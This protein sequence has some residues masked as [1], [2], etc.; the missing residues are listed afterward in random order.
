MSTILVIS[1]SHGANI[2]MQRVLSEWARRVDLI[3]FCGDGCSDITTNI[4]T[5]DIKTPCIKVRGNND[6]ETNIPH[7][8]MFTCDGH[9]IFV[10]HG[11]RYSVYHTP[12]ILCEAARLNDCDI[13]L[14]GHTHIP[15]ESYDKGLYIMNPGSLGYPRYGNKPSFALL[16]ITHDAVYSSFFEWSQKSFTAFTPN[17]Y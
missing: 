15:L 2:L 17:L 11:N 1:D 16:Q 4:A 13:V 7:D 8:T 12:K 5:L 6:W 10:T 9:K 3:V 14:Y